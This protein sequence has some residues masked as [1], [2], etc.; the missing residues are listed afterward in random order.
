MHPDQKV[1]LFVRE[2][3]LQAKEHIISRTV[4]YAFLQNASIRVDLIEQNLDVMIIELAKTI[5]SR[6]ED[7]K[8]YFQFPLNWWEAF[9]LRF[10]SRKLLERFP[11]KYENIYVT[12]EEA[13]PDFVPSIPNKNAVIRVAAFSDQ[14]RPL[15][16]GPV[17]Y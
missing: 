4:D 9:K 11:V 17:G 10:F 2:V 12:L 16:E 8:R 15:C 1:N 6:S 5:Y 14:N 3:L 7:R 13:Y